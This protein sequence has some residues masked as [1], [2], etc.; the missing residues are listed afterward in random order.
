MENSITSPTEMSKTIVYWKAS[1]QEGKAD[2]YFGQDPQVSVTSRSMHY[3]N[4]FF[5]GSVVVVH[6]QERGGHRLYMLHQDWHY[7]RLMNGIEYSRKSHVPFSREDYLLAIVNLLYMNGWDRN[8]PVNFQG[9]RAG[10]IY[11]RPLAYRGASNILPLS[12]PDV[13]GFAIFAFPK[14]SYHGKKGDGFSV[15]AVPEP[16]TLAAPHMKRSDNYP[17]SDLWVERM[18]EFVGW[19]AREKPEIIIDGARVPPGERYERAL[20]MLSGSLKE[21]L[22]CNVGG[23]VTEGSAEN[24]A[25]VLKNYLLT[26]PVEAGALPGFTMQKT[27]LIAEKLGLQPM[28]IG[29]SLGNAKKSDL[30]LLT[31]TAA[32]A[33][34]VDRIV[35]CDWEVDENRNYFPKGP[36]RITSVGTLRGLEIYGKIN[37]EHLKIKGGKSDIGKFGFYAD[38]CLSEKEMAQLREM[39]R[40]VIRRGRLFSP[41]LVGKVPPSAETKLSEGKVLTYGKRLKI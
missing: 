11:V 19:L 1:G 21:V 17:Q 15:L 23:T 5:E 14:P 26:P 13:Y 6:Q 16:R 31:G 20:E 7:A 27:E 25:I 12:G 30:L 35:E 4:T 28:R 24:V 40:E 32:N 34:K 36:V 9:D 8:E 39:A 29:F 41:K 18:K 22:F 10:E 38:E 33:V 2:Q 3:S 37:E